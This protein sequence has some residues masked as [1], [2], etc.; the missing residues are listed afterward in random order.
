MLYLVFKPIIIFLFLLMVIARF[1]PEE[2]R[3]ITYVDEIFVLVVL[4]LSLLHKPIKSKISITILAVI[5]FILYVYLT[6]F[7]S[8]YY[9]GISLTLLDICLFLK[10]V[11]LFLSLI[12]LP[13][14]FLLS[15]VPV[16]KLTASIYIIVAFLC[17]IINMFMTVP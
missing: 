15:M 4:F 12:N 3:I 17:F 7:F 2:F 11:V 1:L 13:R 9:R 6:S 14:S 8:P 5:L 10:P 16:V